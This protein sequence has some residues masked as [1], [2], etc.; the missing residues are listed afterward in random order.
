MLWGDQKGFVKTLSFPRGSFMTQ[1]LQQ[2]EHRLWSTFRQVSLTLRHRCF[3]LKGLMTMT[4]SLVRPSSRVLTAM[5]TRASQR[6]GGEGE[7]SEWGWGRPSLIATCFQDRGGRHAL[8]LR[9]SG[10]FFMRK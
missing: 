6:A 2:P 9:E 5:G 7:S 8:P 3:L 4:R 10:L 1:I